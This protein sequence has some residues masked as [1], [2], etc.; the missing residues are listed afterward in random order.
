MPL[1]IKAFDTLSHNWHIFPDSRK[2]IVVLASPRAVFGPAADGLERLPAEDAVTETMVQP[3]AGLM[4]RFVEREESWKVRFALSDC[5]GPLAKQVFN[6]QY[7]RIHEKE[8]F[9]AGRLGRGIQSSATRK[10]ACKSYNASRDRL[11]G[12]V[13]PTRQR[14]V[15]RLPIRNNQL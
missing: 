2:K 13:E 1:V 10:G 7:I 5:L 12:F 4:F 11:S 8:I 14:P 6:N 3:T 9:A 15:I